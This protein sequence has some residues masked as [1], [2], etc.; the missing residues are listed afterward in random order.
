[1]PMAVEMQAGAAGAAPADGRPLLRVRGVSKR[2]GPVQALIDVD[3]E[4]RQGRGGSAGR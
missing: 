4:V 3:L 1:M 2:F